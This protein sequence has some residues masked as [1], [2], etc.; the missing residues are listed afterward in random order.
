MDISNNY[1]TLLIGLETLPKLKVIKASNNILQDIRLQGVKLNKIVLNQNEIKNIYW[2]YN[3]Q[4]VVHIDISKNQ[5]TKF[6]FSKLKQAEHIDL[7]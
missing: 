5:L 6:N 4:D 3:L 1:I 7:S 2:D